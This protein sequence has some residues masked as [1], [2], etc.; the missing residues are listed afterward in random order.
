[1]KVLLVS[2]L[3]LGVLG[4]EPDAKLLKKIFE[5]MEGESAN[6][7]LLSEV[8]E[9]GSIGGFFS[10][11]E[12]F[13][14][15]DAL[16][17]KNPRFV[18]RQVI[19]QTFEGRKIPAYTLSSSFEAGVNHQKSKVLF[20]GAHHAR[21]LLTPT[22]CLKI[23][24]E[25]VYS[26]RRK[27]TGEEYWRFNE[28][29]IVPVVNIDS[30]RAITDSFGTSDWE[31]AKWK[32]KNMNSEHCPQGQTGVDLNRNYG[33]HF[34][35]D[36]E[37]LDPC[38]ETFRGPTAF[39]EPET[40]AIRDLVEKQGGLIS[41][42]MNFHS[43]GNIWIHPF[44]YMKATRAFPER[45]SQSVQRFYSDFGEEVAKVSAAM[46][47]NA[48]KTVQYATDGE[49]SDW[50]LGE[51]GIVAFS[52]ELGSQNPLAQSF[53]IPKNLINEVIHENFSVIRLFLQK[54]VFRPDGFWFA[55]D[56]KWRLSLGFRNSG[57]TTLF[58]P[59]FKIRSEN[60]KFL[61]AISIVRSL[62]ADLDESTPR[63]SLDR[64]KNE[65]RV[66]IRKI[67]RLSDYRLVLEF[68]SKDAK[69]ENAKLNIDLLFPW[70]EKIA[71]FS[72]NHRGQTP[73]KIMTFL[74]FSL[75]VVAL[76]VTGAF[77]LAKRIE[78][79]PPKSKPNTNPPPKHQVDL[80]QN[81]TVADSEI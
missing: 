3:C 68:K 12:I 42:A 15:F 47:G 70:G 61:D 73:L 31:N 81:I 17:A 56:N 26:L 13:G 10:S 14:I 75:A 5:F 22:I 39:S 24:L 80:E 20:T 79:N 33:Y 40:S 71:S 72:A 4:A 35:E 19:G 50:M 58:D 37:D 65:L 53:F 63:F 64:Q 67:D 78:L 41:S 27:E 1:M 6:Q 76:A 11:E 16:Q 54:N 74:L 48:I 60:L 44:N 23:F 45:F 18:K 28:V 29:I 7:R 77:I 57:L 36:A 9:S 59:I 38:A 66:Q 34:G 32:R 30:H 46:Y 49:A 55:F 8:I 21:E 62:N 43:Y 25:A 69:L 52:P 51:H 2:I